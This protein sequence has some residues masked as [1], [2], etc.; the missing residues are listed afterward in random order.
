MNDPEATASE[1]ACAA[2]DF[3]FERATTW[4]E[5]HLSSCKSYQ[6][7]NHYGRR[8]EKW[9]KIYSRVLGCDKGTTDHT[10]GDPDESDSD[11][12]EPEC[13]CYAKDEEILIEN[14]KCVLDMGTFPDVDGLWSLS[15]EMKINSLPADPDWYL[16]ILSGI[17]SLI[18]RIKH[19]INCI[20][21]GII[22]LQHLEF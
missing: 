13:G 12:S 16:S 15:F 6:K 17:D 9:N 20:F 4:T 10:E 21:Y 7:N 1:K 14:N 3:M 11:E 22:I 8:L 18:Y 5:N 19:I 2:K